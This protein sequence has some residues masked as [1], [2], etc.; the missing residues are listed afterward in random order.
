M[1]MNGT[2][3]VVFAST[4]LASCCLFLTDLL[5]NLPSVVLASIEL[6]AVLGL[7]RA[8]QVTPA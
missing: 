4:T 2:T 5:R 3:G 6:V 8:T 7:S 1:K